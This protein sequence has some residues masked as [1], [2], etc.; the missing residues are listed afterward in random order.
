[1]FSRGAFEFKLNPGFRPDEFRDRTDRV[2][3]GRDVV[4]HLSIDPIR[5]LPAFLFG[6]AVRKLAEE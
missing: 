3:H 6:E 1:M 2:V 5:N 4:G